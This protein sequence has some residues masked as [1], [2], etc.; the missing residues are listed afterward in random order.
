MKYTFAELKSKYSSFI[1]TG[2]TCWGKRFK[3][4]YPEPQWAFA[5]NLWKGSIWG[6]SKETG[7]RKLLKRQY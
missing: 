7:K 5:I 1:I 6:V 3:M 2:V 4:E